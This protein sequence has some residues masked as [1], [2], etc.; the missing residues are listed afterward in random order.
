ME[1]LTEPQFQTELR[2]VLAREGQHKPVWELLNMQQ[3]A[4]SERRSTPKAMMKVIRKWPASL[5][6]A[7][8]CAHP[9]GHA[10][11]VLMEQCEYWCWRKSNKSDHND[12]CLRFLHEH[13]GRRKDIKD[14]AQEA[15]LEHHIAKTIAMRAKGN[16]YRDIAKQTGTAMGTITRSWERTIEAIRYGECY[17]DDIHCSMNDEYLRNLIAGKIND[18]AYRHVDPNVSGSDGGAHQSGARRIVKCTVKRLGG[19]PMPPDPLPVQRH[20][21]NWI[22]EHGRIPFEHDIHHL[23]GNVGDD[24]P[25]NLMLVPSHIHRLVCGNA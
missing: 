13:Y 15:E 6:K 25:T 10:E 12:P 11:D 1:R 20:R 8:I 21:F 17:C 16:S 3:A 18:W 22:R 19:M 4:L 2:A 5:E 24:H 7:A 14:A 23:N 9:Y